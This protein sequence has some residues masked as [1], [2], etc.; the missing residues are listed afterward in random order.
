M[1][2]EPIEPPELHELRGYLEG[3]GDLIRTSQLKW[4]FDTKLF[5]MDVSA[6]AIQELVKAAY[7]QSD[8]YSATITECSDSDM[9]ETLNH[10]FSRWLPSVNHAGKAAM[11]LLGS[12]A[13]LWRYV[14]ACIAHEQFRKFEYSTS[15]RLDEFGA[16]GLSGGFAFVIVSGASRRSLFISGA[17]YD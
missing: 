10:E 15:A 1:K 11:Q 3:M 12:D 2:L 7:P 17:D 9:L 13:Q 6:F 14:K 16:V 5:E 8:P 4:Y